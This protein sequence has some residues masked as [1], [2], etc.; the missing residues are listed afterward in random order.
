[1]NDLMKKTQLSY[2]ENRKVDKENGI[3]PSEKGKVD[4]MSTYLLCWQKCSCFGIENSMYLLRWKNHSFLWIDKHTYF[5]DKIILSFR[6]IENMGWCWMDRDR[7][8]CQWGYGWRDDFDWTN[9]HPLSNANTIDWEQT[10]LSKSIF[11]LFLP[12]TLTI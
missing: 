5:V 8:R 10:W 1:M 7:C 11:Y 3:D 4:W 12:W 2:K 6:L 9:L